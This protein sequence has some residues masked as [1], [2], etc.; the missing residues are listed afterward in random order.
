MNEEKKPNKPLEDLKREISH[1]W[2]TMQE[3]PN[4][5]K[6]LSKR[7]RAEGLEK[8]SKDLKDAGVSEENIMLFRES[9]S[10]LTEAWD[11]EKV[12]LQADSLLTGGLIAISIIILQALISL[13]KLDTPA[14]VSIVAL[15]ISMPLSASFLFIRFVQR[16]Y[17]I[18]TYEWRIISI[19]TSVSYIIGL[20]GITAAIWHA[21]PLAGV[22]FLIVSI[23]AIIFSV[24]YYGFASMRATYKKRKAATQEHGDQPDST[25]ITEAKKQSEEADEL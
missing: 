10:I 4:L 16:A 13:G 20:I 2:K 19:L 9:M 5:L 6:L 17:E 11:N 12:L 21:S 22:V 18:N 15:S 23:S 8:M 25:I 7:K 24:V 1:L 3:L 14:T